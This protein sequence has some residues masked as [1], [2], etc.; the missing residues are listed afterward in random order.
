MKS[1]FILAVCLFLNFTIAIRAQQNPVKIGVVGLTHTH[2]HWIFSSEKLGDIKI[3]GIVETNKELAQRYADQYGFAMTMVYDTMDEMIKET[4]PEAVSAFGSIYE[5]LAVVEKAAPLGIHVMVEKPL[6]VSLNHAKKMQALAKKH[7]IHLL[8]NYETTWY[9]TNHMAYDLVQKDS[10]GEIRKV[11][12]HDGHKGPKK[13][14]VNKE[15]LDWLTDPVQNGG[16]AI[17]DFGCYGINLMTWLMKGE[18]PLTVTAVTQQQQPENNPKVDDDATIIL[19]YPKANAIIQASW[20]WPI[21]RK[22]MEI[23]GLDGVIYADNRN[24]MR[25]RISEGYD[26][27][28]EEVFKLEERIKPYNDPFSFFAAVIRKEITVKPFDLSSLENNML[29]VEILDAAIKSA[30]TGETV[31]LKH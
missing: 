16:G 3:V 29:V 23:Y 9:P 1:K 22:D 20:D 12:V 30:Q 25:L 6:A 31:H 18:K 21:G 19:T 27:F 11:V 10:I 24:D 8:T 4:K 5:H 28:S 7:N 14:G 2:V 26:G 13:I 17:T 15:F